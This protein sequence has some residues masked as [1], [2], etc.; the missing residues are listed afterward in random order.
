MT[1]IHKRLVVEFSFWNFKCD[2]ITDEIPEQDF[3]KVSPS[4]LLRTVAINLDIGFFRSLI[5][6]EIAP[7]LVSYFLNMVKLR[8][9]NDQ[10]S[11]TCEVSNNFFGNSRTLPCSPAFYSQTLQ[12]TLL[13]NTTIKI[14]N[15]TVEAS[16]IT[17]ISQSYL[18][19]IGSGYIQADKAT[20]TI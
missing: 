10:Q 16:V 19:Q 20:H 1:E 13:Y 14:W 4:Y 8:S 3:K 18:S 2:V 7:P 17:S 5:R 11:N 6:S 12:T 9:E 15:Q